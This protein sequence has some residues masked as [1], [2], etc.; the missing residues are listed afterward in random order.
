MQTLFELLGVGSCTWND[1]W[2]A[3]QSQGVPS[4][5]PYSRG[6]DLAL[7]AERGHTASPRK[8]HNG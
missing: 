1:Q 5:T 2:V 7:G 3:G 4:P 8:A 6:G